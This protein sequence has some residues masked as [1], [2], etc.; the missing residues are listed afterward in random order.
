MDGILVVVKPP[1]PTSHDVVALV[2]RLSGTRRVGHGGTLDP[3]ATGVLPLYL[4][5]ATRLVEYHLGDS[6]RYRA[7]VCFGAS[8]TTDDIEGELTPVDG[9]GPS[10]AAVEAAL[11]QFRGRIEQVPP[12][13]SAVKVAGRR[14]YALA[15]AGDAPKLAPRGVTIDSLDL[16]EWDERDPERPIAVIDVECSA[17]TYVRSL[18]RDL[19]AAV[20]NAAHLGA[21]ARTRS[22]P[23]GIDDAI[24]LERV[25][26]TAAAG[27]LAALLQRPDAGLEAFPAVSLSDE[28]AAAIL[29]GQFI[30]PPQPLPPLVEGARYRLLRADGSLLAIAGL[31]D[32]R[33]AP[34]KV[35]AGGP[36]A[37]AARPPVDGAAAT[38]AAE[39]ARRTPS[40]TTGRRPRS[41]PMRVVPGLAALTP[42]EGRLFVVVGVFD[43]L[44][45]GHAYLLEQ[46]R[47]HARRLRARP[48]VVTFDAHP[49]EILHGHAPPVLVDPAERLVR[50]GDAGVAVTVVQH[51]DAALRMTPYDRFVAMITERTELAGFLM[52]PDAA[53]GHQRGGT[54]ET[55]AALG[56]AEGFEVVVV[57][58]FDLDGR[59][60]RSA[61]VRDDISAGDLAGAAALLGRP[62]AVV[63]ERSDPAPDA[64]GPVTL[65]FRLPVALPPDGRYDVLVELPLAPG[66][67]R[68]APVPATAVISGARVRLE[69]LPALPGARLRVSFP[70]G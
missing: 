6:K 66:R 36:P 9:P 45:L 31:R 15:R 60:V 55:V 16:V 39:A 53:F 14:A 42:A 70:G 52:T 29:K 62:V 54:A 48:A 44:H 58:P 27:D 65:T 49:E 46:L 20:G 23:F 38:D 63:G 7:T 59:Q 26:T 22:G 18:A 5:R 30:R 43:G 51:F 56:R 61:E 32:G 34:E 24:P 57:P 37:P 50:L 40:E 28:D 25:R 33:L 3:F 17:G 68:S 21:L 4:G 8:S 13:Y 1:G 64:D 10:R 35:L 67:E 47:A 69:A 12:G 19:G 41:S 2:R 11:P